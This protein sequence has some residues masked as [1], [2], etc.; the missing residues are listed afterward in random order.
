MS[1]VLFL[2]KNTYWHKPP[3]FKGR[4]NVLNNFSRCLL[5]L[6]RKRM[7]EV[8]ALSVKLAITILFEDV[9]KLHKM[10]ITVRITL[11][12]GSG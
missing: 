9:C 3:F 10:I 6:I 7:G 4:R 11:K 1:A 5:K 12:H 2:V 8:A